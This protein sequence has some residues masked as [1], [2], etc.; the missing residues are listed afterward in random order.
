MIE[1]NKL[2]ISMNQKF[3]HIISPVRT[4]VFNHVLN[5]R[6]LLPHSFHAPNSNVK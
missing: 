3:P 6:P 1:L 4:K 5:I 2:C